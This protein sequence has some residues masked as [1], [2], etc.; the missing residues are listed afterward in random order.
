M[1]VVTL[2]LLSKD[3]KTSEIQ[4]Q[5][6][7]MHEVTQKPVFAHIENLSKNLKKQTIKGNKLQKREENIV[8]D[9]QNFIFGFNIEFLEQL[10]IICKWLLENNISIPNQEKLNI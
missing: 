10:D 5:L 3:K 9:Q 1:E 7:K 6:E 8:S 2:E 4:E